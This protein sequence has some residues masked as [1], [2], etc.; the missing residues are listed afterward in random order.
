MKSIKE[1]LSKTKLTRSDALL[2]III[3]LLA[4]LTI[5]VLSVSIDQQ[6]LDTFEQ[7]LSEFQLSIDITN[8]EANIFGDLYLDYALSDDLIGVCGDYDCF[9][10][11]EIYNEKSETFEDIGPV[12][13][14]NVAESLN[15]Y[16]IP[17]NLFEIDGVDYTEDVDVR[18]VVSVFDEDEEVV[19]RSE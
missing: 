14:L 5:I 17:H 11:A 19:V 1:Y 18:L 8:T 15:E 9:M 7:T 2:V 4:V 16:V 12:Q 3:A 13:E 10:T 6:E